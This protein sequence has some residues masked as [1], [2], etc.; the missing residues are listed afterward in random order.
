MTVIIMCFLVPF[1]IVSGIAA[2]ILIGQWVEMK[3]GLKTPT[4]PQDRDKTP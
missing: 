1:A 3:L 4:Q 2:P